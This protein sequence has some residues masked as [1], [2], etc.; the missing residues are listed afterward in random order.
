MLSLIH[1]LSKKMERSNG[2]VFDAFEL[3][4]SEYGC[5]S[6]KIAPFIIL[7]DE[8]NLSPIEHYWAAFLR[9]CDFTSV[10]NRSIP[11]GGV[12]S[13]KPVSY[14]HLLRTS[15]LRRKRSAS[16][17]PISGYRVRTLSPRRKRRKAIA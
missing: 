1:I 5:D 15:I 8:A 17:N 3:M 7:L 12:K 2:E 9:N 4:D 16:I 6:S 11:L 14:T 13:F 10:S